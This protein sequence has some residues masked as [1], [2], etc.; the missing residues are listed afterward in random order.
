MGDLTH[1]ALDGLLGLLAS[2]I[3]NEVK[4]QRSVKR[5]IMFI[6]D[7]MDSMNGFLLHL[8]KTETVHNDQHRAWMKQV[9]EIA[10]AAQDSIQ[11]YMRDLSPPGT[12]FWQ[13]DYIS[14]LPT[15]L[16]TCPKRRR[17]AK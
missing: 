5:D 16:L 11:L 14:H 10:Y 9:R 2:A 6:K 8:T 3:K 12:H 7:K 13:L 1:T 15:L 4:L 17:L